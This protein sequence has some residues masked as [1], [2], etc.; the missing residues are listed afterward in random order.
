MEGLSAR[1]VSMTKRLDPSTTTSK[2]GRARLGWFIVGAGA[3]AVAVSY[4]LPTGDDAAATENRERRA[5]PVVAA[6]VERSTLTERGR[7]PGELDADAADVSSFYTGR[8]TAVHV[9]VGDV[10]AKGQ[11]LA[12]IDPIDAREQIARARAQAQAAAAEEQRAAIE[13]GVARR[14]LERYERLSDQVSASDI[15]AQRALAEALE[16]AVATAAAREAEARAGVRLL[17][18]RVVE[19]EIR[20]PFAGRVAARHVDPGVIVD[21]GAPLIRVAATAPLRVR[22]EVPEQDVADLAVGTGLRVATQA[23]GAGGATA[24]VAAKVTGIA[25]EVSR[26]RRVATLEALLESPPPSWLPGMYAQV[27]VDRRVIQGATVVPATAVLSRLQPDGTIATGVLIADGEVARWV[28]V[29]VAAREDDRVAIEVASG[30]LAPGTR[31]LVAGHVDLTHGSPIQVAA[32]RA[33][34]ERR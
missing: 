5:T 2:P 11:V 10:V 19:S 6:P 31:V 13:L 22:F 32:D 20:A 28:P 30:A 16:T 3:V 9:R 1:P 25:G 12:E 7:Y 15:D 33:R 17:E 8:L 18:K 24:G 21:A 27:I 29:K 23:Q 26:D 34:A 4:A 14:Q